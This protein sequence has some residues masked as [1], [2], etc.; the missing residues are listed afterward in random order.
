MARKNT[1]GPQSTSF[2]KPTV[3]TSKLLKRLWK[4]L[5]EY[6]FLLIVSIIISIICNLLA[7]LGPKLSGHAVDAIQL[8]VG[9][10]DFQKVFYYAG[11]MIIIYLIASVLSYLLAVLLV[12]IGSRVVYNLRNDVYEHLME[13]PIKFYDSNAIG[14]IISVLNYDI[15]TVQASLSND[16]VQMLA[17]A[18]T[19]LGSLWMMLTISPKLVLIFTVTIPVSI[20]LTRYRSKKVRPL[21]RT[22]SNDLGD[23]NGY[24]EEITGG[25]KTI[26]VYNRQ[27]V[28]IG[29]FQEKNLKTSE[30]NYKADSFASS[31]GPSVSFINNISMA[32]ISFFGAIL[33]MS[34]S[35]SLGNVSSFVLYSRKFSGPI[36]EFSNIISELQS[37]LAA[38]ERIFRLLDQEVELKDNE[39][40]ISIENVKGHIEF[41]D[42][43]FGY[44][45]DEL[46]LKDYNL[47]VKPGQV[48]A[49]VGPTGAGK[50]TIIN[51]LMRFYD[52]DSGSIT[53]DGID[54]RDIKRRDLRNAFSMVL[55]DTWLFTG[56]IKENLI[57]GREDVTE[58][59]MI[60]AAKTAKIHDFIISMPN[61]Y[62][63][64]LRES[65]SNISKGQK[66]LLTIARAMLLDSPM[67]ILDEATS[68]VDTQTE[69]IIQD[70]MLSLMEDRTSFVIAHRLST[71]QNADLIAVLKD[72]KVLEIGKHSELIGTNGYYAE[73]YKAQFETIEE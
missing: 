20:M 64:I 60:I 47:S 35:I 25:L 62:N 39:D 66:Q 54:I 21:Y 50:T 27:E 56:T 70:A 10:V 45:E 43:S 3:K 48:V 19:I 4:Y 59:E 29:D 42:V 33:F 72:G 28:F 23:L 30:S 18:I 12:K 63:T 67:L 2:E 24:I 46:I 73:L 36:N 40:A 41:K 57:Y 38:A 68:N 65:G 34:G 8:G 51:L 13:L 26:T 32:L 58:E 15:D 31:T 22:R 1:R 52:I 44:T 6:K 61:G 55:Q 7:L 49:I 17:S 37:S 16:L 69:R 71:I 9:K 53:L 14:D 11:L 5:I